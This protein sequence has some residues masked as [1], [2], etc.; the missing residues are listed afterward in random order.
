[1]SNKNS[2]AEQEYESR[3]S[4]PYKRYVQLY[5]YHMGREWLVEQLE[6][7]GIACYDDEPTS[8]FVAAFT[9]SHEAGDLKDIP[10]G[11]FEAKSLS[12]EMYMAYLD[13]DDRWE[14]V[15]KVRS[16]E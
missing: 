14:R 6:S 11:V 16:S 3:L 10:W 9:D 2:K 15:P 8:D 12:H 1:M 5:A 7:I 4:D 13:V